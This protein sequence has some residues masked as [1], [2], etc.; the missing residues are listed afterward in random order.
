[1][2][3]ASC[4]FLATSSVS[5]SVYFVSIGYMKP[6]CTLT[7]KSLLRQRRT[8]TSVQLRHPPPHHCNIELMYF[9]FLYWTVFTHKEIGMSLLV[10]K[11]ED[12]VTLRS[13]GGYKQTYQ[14]SVLKI[15]TAYLCTLS[16]RLESVIRG[17]F[18]ATFSYG[19]EV[20][21]TMECF[22]CYNY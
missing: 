11:T 8:T 10:Q 13:C 20:C 16:Y 6:L 2:A 12:V 14:I 3:E 21:I 17:N 7:S 22:L 18:M 4:C 19:Q 9:G 5:W 1:L 15:C